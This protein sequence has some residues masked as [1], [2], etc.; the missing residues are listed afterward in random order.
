M[1]RS[2]RSGAA[3]YVWGCLGSPPSQADAAN[4]FKTA[5]RSADLISVFIAHGLFPPS[6]FTCFVP[7]KDVIPLKM[8]V[9]D[10]ARIILSAGM[11]NPRTRTP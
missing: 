1:Q 11:A 6:G 4:E 2:L 9:E 5:A 7:R 8:S 10:A 3:S